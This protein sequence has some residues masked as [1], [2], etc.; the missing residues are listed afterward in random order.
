MACDS[1]PSEDMKLEPKIP[2]IKTERFK[3]SFLNRCLFDY[4]N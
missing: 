2:M 4:F 3:R 1:E